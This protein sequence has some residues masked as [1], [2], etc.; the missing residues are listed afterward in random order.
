M[1]KL[2]DR[3][4]TLLERATLRRVE[5]GAY[6]HAV[7][8]HAAAG[9]EVGAD[10]LA[11]PFLELGELAAAGLDDGLDLLLGLFGYGDHSVQVLVH[12]QPD[13][14]LERRVTYVGKSRPER[15]TTATHFS[16]LQAHES[17]KNRNSVYSVYILYIVL[18]ISIL[19]IYL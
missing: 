18:D 12:K 19:T 8:L 11:R 9:L 10:P 17:H 3:Y 14:H 6:L 15:R 1:S 13:K 7:L 2:F 5:R 16:F 4:R